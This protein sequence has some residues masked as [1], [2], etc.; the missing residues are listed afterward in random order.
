MIIENIRFQPTTIHRKQNNQKSCSSFTSQS[1]SSWAQTTALQPFQI[2]LL[3]DQSNIILQYK[4]TLTITTSLNCT[5]LFTSDGHMFQN[6]VYFHV[7][8]H[9]SR[10]SLFPHVWKPQLSLNEPRF[11]V[12]VIWWIWWFLFPLAW[13]DVCCVS[14]WWTLACVFRS[15]GRGVWMWCSSSWTGAQTFSS[16]ISLESQ[17]FT[18]PQR[19][20]TRTWFSSCWTEKVFMAS[21][22]ELNEPSDITLSVVPRVSS[23]LQWL[24][25]TVG[26]DGLLKSSIEQWPTATLGSLCQSLCICKLTTKSCKITT[27][28]Q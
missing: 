20:T 11:S 8:C 12:L 24:M 1:Y 16:R 28:V 21:R 14:V 10:V 7:K 6:P 13:F 5:L 22:R 27:V 9:S 25:G 23:L 4:V 18:W 2:V 17:R 26:I 19:W 15:P 3:F